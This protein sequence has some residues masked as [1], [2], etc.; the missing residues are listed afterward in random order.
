VLPNP[1]L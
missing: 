1:E